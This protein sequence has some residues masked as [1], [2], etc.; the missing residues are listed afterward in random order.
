MFT[1]QQKLAWS[2]KTASSPF[3]PQPQHPGVNSR[4]PS[5][6]DATHV[7]WQDTSSYKP[8]F[9]GPPYLPGMEVQGT[10]VASKKVASVADTVS[11][12]LVA[13]LVSLRALALL[14]QTHHWLSDG[15]EYYADHLLFERLYNETVEEIDAIGER[16]V[17]QGYALPAIS[18]MSQAMGVAKFLETTEVFDS[19]CK[20]SL[21]AEYKFRT[22][23]SGAVAKLKELNALSRG[24]DNLLAG[25]EDKHEGHVY[26]LQ[27]R[28]SS[29]AWKLVQ[30]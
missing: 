5:A 23:I 24:T 28:T 22:V 30:N 20:R 26:L 6:G 29:K 18:P 15:P 21:S 10:K 3:Y 1:K 2:T 4:V 19:F 17:G 8:L 14:H 9:H 13:V 12:V 25:I 7:I 16:A 11:E 27:Q